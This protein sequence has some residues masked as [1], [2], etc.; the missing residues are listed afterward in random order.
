[1]AAWERVRGGAP[2]PPLAMLLAEAPGGRGGAARRL[3]FVVVD[4]VRVG[5]ERA[6]ST[7]EGMLCETIEDEV[8]GVKLA[9]VLV[10]TVVGVLL[11]L[12]VLFT[13]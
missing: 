1:M 3:L 5:V 11:L 8:V 6:E 10:V 12:L 2:W 13:P 7:R 4:E 9:D